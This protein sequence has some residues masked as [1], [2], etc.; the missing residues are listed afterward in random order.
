MI[1]TEIFTYSIVRSSYK[2]TCDTLVQSTPRSIF[3]PNKPKKR[4]KNTDSSSITV[5][6]REYNVF[7]P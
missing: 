2:K 1:P 3:E 6:I 5:F 4:N 7:I